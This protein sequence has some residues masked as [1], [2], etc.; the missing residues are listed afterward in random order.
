MGTTF[1]TSEPN[2]M[3]PEIRKKVL[4]MIPYGMY[5]ITAKH[6]DKLAAG[7]IDWVTQASFEPPMV[8]CCLRQDS[9]IYSLVTGSK[10]YAIHPLGA[11]QKQYAMNFFKNKDATATHINGQAYQLSSSGIPIL[12]EPPASFELEMVEQL[13][14]SDHAVIL[15]KVTAVTLKR[16]E[17]PLLLRDTGWQYGG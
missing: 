2:V 10:K 5:V 9:F 1:T 16:E 17:L 7:T 8:V 11:G 6:E 4:R 14:Q 12:D 13:K 15:G 3:D